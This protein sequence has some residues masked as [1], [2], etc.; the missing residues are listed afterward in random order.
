MHLGHNLIGKD[1]ADQAPQ[2]SVVGR[3][4]VEHMVAEQLQQRWGCRH[5]SPFVWRQ[6]IFYALH[7]PLVVTQQQVDIIVAGNKPDGGLAIG[8]DAAVEG[9]LRAQGRVG[10]VGVGFKFRAKKVERAR[11][12]IGWYFRT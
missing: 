9:R 3:V 10:G 8:R 7:K 1:F 12:D 2:P 11:H 6:R 4:E 5:K